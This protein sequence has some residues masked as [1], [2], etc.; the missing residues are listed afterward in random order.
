MTVED[1]SLDVQAPYRVAATW[2]VP[3][4]ETPHSVAVSPDGTRAYVTHFLSGEISVVDTGTRTVAAVFQDSPGIYGVAVSPGGDHL[5]VANPGTQFVHRIRVGDGMKD[6]SAGIG[7]AP[8][9]LAM[10]ADGRLYAACPLADSVEVLDGLVKNVSRLNGIGFAVCVAGHADRLY[11]S[12][13]FAGSI[14]EIDIASIPVGT[15]DGQ[16]AVT[17]AGAVAM[18]PYGLA[19]SPDGDHLF[20]A[21]FNQPSLVTVIRTDTLTQVQELHVGAGPVRGVAMAPDGAALYVT[22]Y[23]SSAVMVVELERI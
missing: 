19:L 23:F 10:G 21:H 15:F 17:A 9:G 13:Y 18:S 11:A 8:Y 2:S 6:L 4:A 1:R 7:V 5:Y 20:I 22:D 3:V 12:R 14:A 16:A